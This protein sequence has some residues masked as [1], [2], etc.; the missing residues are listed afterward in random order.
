M[1]TLTRIL[2]VM[3]AIGLA[4]AIIMALVL[5]LVLV[6]YIRDELW[7]RRL[8]RRIRRQQ[9]DLSDSKKNEPPDMT[10]GRPK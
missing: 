8:N 4:L 7:L 1:E 10:E 3:R 5:L 9:N 6:L 2:E